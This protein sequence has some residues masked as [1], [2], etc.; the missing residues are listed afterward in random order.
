MKVKNEFGGCP[1]CG[2]ADGFLEEWGCYVFFCAQHETR[3]IIGGDK[4]DNLQIDVKEERR[5]DWRNLDVENFTLVA[6]VYDNTGLH[7]DIDWRLILSGMQALRDACTDQGVDLMCED[8]EESRIVQW[9]LGR[10]EHRKH[11]FGWLDQRNEQARA[12]KD[13]YQQ[14]ATRL[15][16]RE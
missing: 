14:S 1:Q 3:W 13:R 4:L 6:P 15:V 5:T 9:I 7:T 11:D 16:L 12:Y 8:A 2:Q 10:V